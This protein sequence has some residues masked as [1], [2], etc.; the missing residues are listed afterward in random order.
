MEVILMHIDIYKSGVLSNF[1]TDSRESQGL[2]K[3]AVSMRALGRFARIKGRN[4][5]TEGKNI[6]SR[7][8]GYFTK[9][10]LP[11][12]GESNLNVGNASTLNQ[13]GQRYSH[14]SPAQFN[15]GYLPTI[16]SQ[17]STSKIIGNDYLNF[18]RKT[19]RLN[20]YIIKKKQPYIGT[21]KASQFDNRLGVLTRA[22]SS[23]LNTTNQRFHNMSVALA[24]NAN[25]VSI[26]GAP[27]TRLLNPNRVQRAQYAIED[28]V[29]KV[30]STIENSAAVRGASRTY[31]QANAYINSRLQSAVNKINSNTDSVIV[32]GSKLM[33]SVQ[34]RGSAL[35]NNAREQG[36]NMIN[37]ARDR[38]SSMINSIREQG[39]SVVNNLR[40]KFGPQY[41]PP[42]SP[43][44][45]Q[46][47][48]GMTGGRKGRTTGGQAQP[49]S[50]AQAQLQSQ[51][52]PQPQSQAQAQAH[53][54]PKAQENSSFSIP[55]Y[56]KWG[57]G[58]AGLGAAGAAAYNYSRSNQDRD[59]RESIPKMAS[60]YYKYAA[61][62]D[63]IPMDTRKPA[64]NQPADG[65]D[66]Y[67]WQE[68]MI[69]DGPMN[70][71]DR[72][73]H[74]TLS[75]TKLA[76]I[77][78]LDAS[79]RAHIFA[80]KYKYAAAESNILANSGNRLLG[81]SINEA[82]QSQPSFTQQLIENFRRPAYME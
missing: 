60:A 28:A 66:Y 58:A 30:P 65:P 4:A 77:L 51:A 21:D 82:A 53:P 9:K 74:P 73:N 5:I 45:V 18:R 29:K 70:T 47:L 59:A 15:N 14:L 32:N 8:K 27:P 55:S 39:N 12:V 37:T 42:S 68:Y 38:G 67:D 49:Q 69:Q 64:S 6:L 46:P 17:T 26:Q 43:R 35:L 79:T 81:A 41:I 63:N 71:P 22:N 72:D 11:N 10:S 52:Q 19:N 13:H 1:P 34:D 80:Q 16:N 33:N 62:D 40:S 56:A 54:Q 23:A 57:L 61:M 20:N 48:Q 36:S 31:N 24:N 75:T 76:N 7:G 44:R 25:K 2:T 50:Q 3:E 78:G